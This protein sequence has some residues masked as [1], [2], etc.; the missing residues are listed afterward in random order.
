MRQMKRVV[1]AL[2]VIFFASACG[3]SSTTAPTPAPTPPVATTFNL[4][5]TVTSTAGGGITGATVR[6][7]D[8]ANAGKSTTTTAGGAYSFTGLAVAGQTVNAS[9]TNYSSVSKGV[10]T[11]SNQVLDFQ[12][13]P[14]PLFA[15]SGVGNTVF[16]VPD[17]VL[18]VRITGTYTGSSSNFVMWLGPQNVAC[19][20]VIA[21]GCRLLV[22]A[23]IGTSW[24]T[25]S[26]DSTLL[27]GNAGTT[28]TGNLTVQLST[29]VSWTFTEVR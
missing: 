8:G 29:G 2:S 22:N 10:S 7:V 4:T 3:S 6:I 21:A 23:L 16:D 14:T 25:T 19:G 27:T 26:Y 5:G 15:R 9:A 1:S 17:T 20:V 13:A 12:L 28:A 18:K 24:G 11:T